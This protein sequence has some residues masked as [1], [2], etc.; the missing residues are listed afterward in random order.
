MILSFLLVVLVDNEPVSTDNML[1][2]D[3]VRCNYFA[4]AIEMRQTTTNKYRNYYK[5]NITAY[6]IPTMSSS[7][8][9]YY[10]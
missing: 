6:C 4:T 3:I 1:F 5:N 8:D 2:R 10:D 7:K 9:K